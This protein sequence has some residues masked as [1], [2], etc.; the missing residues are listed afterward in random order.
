MSAAPSII[1]DP[2]STPHTVEIDLSGVPFSEELVH[3]ARRWCQR[4]EEHVG[5][6]LRWTVNI[7]RDA[8]RRGVRVQ[9][10]AHS[11]RNLRWTAEGT[12][13]DEMLA[14]RNAFAWIEHPP[15]AAS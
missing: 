7:Q 6:R 5:Q 4:C 10:H 11:G 13:L 3:Y 9:V 1:P 8:E 2:M 12:D 14:V 15:A